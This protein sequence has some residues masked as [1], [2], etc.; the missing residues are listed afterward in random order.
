[1][2]GLQKDSKRQKLGLAGSDYLEQIDAI[3]EQYEFKP[4]S[5]VALNRR[6]SLRDWA[7]D[8]TN[9]GDAVAIPESVMDDALQINYRE[10][11]MDQL[12]AIYDTVRNIEHLAN[13]KNKIIRKREQINFSD[14]VNELV[15]SAENSNLKSLGE[16]DQINQVGS[17]IFEKGAKAWRRFDASLLKIEQMIEWLDGGNINGPWA[18]YVFDMV[19]DAQTREYDL[20]KTITKRLQD[21]TESMPKGW[22]SSM[23][24]RTP[25]TLPGIS[26]PLSKY[27][28][29]SIALNTGN[30]QNLQRLRDGRQWSQEQIDTAL[31]NLTATDWKFVQDVWDTLETLWPEL[32]ALEKRQSGLEPPKVEPRAFEAAGIELKGGYFPLVYDK[33]LS[34]VGEKQAENTESI[35]QFFSRGFGRPATDRGAT[36]ARVDNF[37]APLKLDF[38]EVLSSHVAKV[39]KDISHREAVLGVNKI[40]NN[41]SVKSTMIDKLGESRYREFKNWLQVIVNDRA[42]T[43]HQARGISNLVMHARTNTA[44]VTM[45]YKISTMLSQFAGLG[46]ALDMVKP[47]FLTS[48]LVEFTKHPKKTLDFVMEKSGEMRHRQNT[49]ERDTK[50]ALRQMREPQSKNPVI[51]TAQS[52]TRPIARSAFYLTAMA[53]R[54]ISV[55]IWLGGYRQAL[56]NGEQ[57]EAAIRAG[58]RA[59]RLSQGAG[60]AKDLAAVQRDNDLLKLLTMYYTPFSVLYARLRDVGYSTRGMGDLPKAVARSIALVMLPAVMGDILAGRGPEDDEDEVWWAARK[61][62]LYPLASIP[63]LRDFSGYLESGIIKASGEGEMRFA[64]SYKLSPVVGSLEKIARVPGKL[65][66]VL[67]GS[68]DVN[69]VAWDLFETSGYVFGLPT[70]QPRITGEYIYDVMSGEESPD[71]LPEFVANTLFRRSN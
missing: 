21:I 10:L 11:P 20:H 7:A 14:V 43:I 64:P 24:D 71:D 33:N 17:S 23:T 66:D 35:T 32:A 28:L 27:D 16:L 4:V 41:S 70:A 30:E 49:I 12:R 25:A 69:D 50:E 61:T 57:E 42:D 44:I 2:R 53:D 26:K 52:V 9:E 22:L 5:N 19:D 3:L 31:S 54:T 8:K 18:R 39:V 47:R 45:G 55:P 63:V 29:I 40:L 62:V 68:K 56:A 59:V 36:K 48:S 67:D 60:G 6:K 38:E 46:P 51:G 15:T 37:A 13:L 34:E 1:M 58:D 65:N